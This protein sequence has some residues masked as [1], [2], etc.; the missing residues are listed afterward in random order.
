MFM[1]TSFVQKIDLE[2]IVLEGGRATFPVSVNIFSLQRVLEGK[3]LFD[4]GFG[5]IWNLFF[6]LNIS[7]LC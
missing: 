5:K 7:S 3:I 6:F 4:E 1:L 2:E